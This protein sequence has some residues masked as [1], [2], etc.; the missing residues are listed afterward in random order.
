MHVGRHG[1]GVGAAKD[2]EAA[3]AAAARERS[4]RRLNMAPENKDARGRLPAPARPSKGEAGCREKEDETAQKKA[5]TAR[6][7]SFAKNKTSGQHLRV[8]KSHRSRVMD[9]Y[10]C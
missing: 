4:T 9:L 7:R 3:A 6:A 8:E 5:P 1:V 2:D 10:N